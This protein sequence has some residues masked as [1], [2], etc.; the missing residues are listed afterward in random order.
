MKA[1]V[2]DFKLTVQRSINELK[3]F[4]WNDLNDPNTI[5]VWPG[6]V[7]LVLSVLLFVALVA[8]GYWF[9]IKDL[10]AE[11]ATVAGEESG[12]RADLESK[13][14]LA[15]NLESYRQQMKDM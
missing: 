6:P 5:G 14:V 10:Q 9:Y 11:L 1:V 8:A 3:T 7:K 2:E 15:A 13:A 12:L 4:N